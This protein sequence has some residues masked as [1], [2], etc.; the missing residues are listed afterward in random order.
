M[1]LKRLDLS[2]SVAR[3]CREASLFLDFFLRFSGSEGYACIM[4]I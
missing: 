2:Y 1:V 4:E 3:V